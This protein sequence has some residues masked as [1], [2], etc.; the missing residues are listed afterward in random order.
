MPESLYELAGGAEGC[1]RIASIFYGYMFD[2]PLML[3][4]FE[5]LSEDHVG[6][7]ALWLGEY[8]GGPRE[9]SKQRGGFYTMVAVHQPLS[10]SDAQ[11]DRWINYMMAACEEAGMPEAVIAYFT[12]FIYSGAL[13][14]QRNSRRD[15]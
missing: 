1:Q 3:P 14:A 7:M 8:F 15:G 11:R 12:P 13:A 9:H 5:D 4:L 2:D 10:I 6:R